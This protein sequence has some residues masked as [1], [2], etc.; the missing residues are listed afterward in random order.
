MGLHLNVPDK[1]LNDPSVREHRNRVWW[2]AYCFDRM[3]AAKLGY[4]AAIRDDE[5]EL[6]LPSNPV[7]D[8]YSSSDF[9][10]RDYF[11]AR[12]GLSRLSGRIIHSIYTQRSPQRSLSLRVQEAFRDL[13]GWLEKLPLSLRIDSKH[14]AEL[15]PRA[16]SLHLLFN[17]V[18]LSLPGTF[19]Y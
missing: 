13:R 16:R 19:W 5:I 12:I 10:D 7:C 3:W 15:D 14:E 8:E 17:Q 4:P 1:Q 18:C 9:P 6:D 11:V 2:T